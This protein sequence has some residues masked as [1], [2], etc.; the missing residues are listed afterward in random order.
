MMKKRAL[1]YGNQKCFSKFLKCKFQDLLE[2]DVCKDLKFLTEDLQV[3]SVVVFVIY[4]E[5]DLIDFFKI[6]SK[7][8]PLVVCAF[9]K[10]ILDVL[11]GLENIIL[12]DTT[13]IRSEILNQLSF[14]FEEEILNI[15]LPHS[16]DYK[17]MVFG[18]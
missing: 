12:V 3:Y 17:E 9:N 10:R 8:I 5:E 2:F 13:K 16:V 18:C 6:Y 1:I 15:Q 7:G 11:I 4:A 14:Y